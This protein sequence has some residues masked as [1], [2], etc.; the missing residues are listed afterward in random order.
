MDAGGSMGIKPKGEG[1][2]SSLLSGRLF[3]HDNYI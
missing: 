2:G 3:F 1:S